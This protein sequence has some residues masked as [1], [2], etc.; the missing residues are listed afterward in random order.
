MATISSYSFSLHLASTLLT[1]TLATAIP[2]P[3]PAPS[4][5]INQP[6]PPLSL[7]SA[8]SN[9]SFDNVEQEFQQIRGFSPPTCDAPAYGQALRLESCREAQ[10]MIPMDRSRLVFGVRNRGRWAVNL[11]YRWSSCGCFFFRLLFA[12]FFR[13]HFFLLFTCCC[14]ALLY[15]AWFCVMLMQKRGFGLTGTGWE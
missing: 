11:P 5:P 6:V 8:P 2:F 3:P 4:I 13:L 10:R 1:L 12:F 15:F 7:W 14:F 9:A